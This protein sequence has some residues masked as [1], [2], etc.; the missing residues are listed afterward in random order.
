MANPANPAHLLLDTNAILRYLRN[1]IPKQADAVRA[2]LIEAQAG[3]LIIDVHPLILA[4]ALFV[5]QS[6]YKQPSRKI[7]SVLQTFLNTPG[8]RIQEESRVRE[9]LTRY[10][11]KNVSFID[12]YLAALGAETSHPIF[13]FDQGLDKFKDI[14][15]VEK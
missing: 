10:A 11:D 12:A 8:I 14:Q 1:D 2:R 4:E 9:A 13:S 7:A 5:L 15:R 6:F 3:R